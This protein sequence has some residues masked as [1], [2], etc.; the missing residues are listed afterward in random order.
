MR[1]ALATGRASLAGA[2]G[3]CPAL[4]GTRIA[5]RA[6]RNV[7]R[8]AARFGGAPATPSSRGVAGA[9]ESVLAGVATRFA[10]VRCLMASGALLRHG[11]VAC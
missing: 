4:A 10:A 11:G 6:A 1:A 8:A 9:D 7:L 2:G 3:G 5:G